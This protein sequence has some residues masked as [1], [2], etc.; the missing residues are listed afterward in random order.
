MA[1]G[2][3]HTS[4][5]YSI[6]GVPRVGITVGFPE[7]Q[8]FPVSLVFS[9]GEI[10]WKA[11]AHQTSAFRQIMHAHIVKDAH[12]KGTRNKMWT[13]KCERIRSSRYRV[14]GRCCVGRMMGKFRERDLRVEKSV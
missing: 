10:K 4:H 5:E 6:Y 1:V 14:F 12:V 13:L 3:L 7:V 2:R 8:S 9:L 11:R